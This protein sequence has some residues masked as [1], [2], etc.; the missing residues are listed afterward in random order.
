M[1]K[2]SIDAGANEDFMRKQVRPCPVQS[3]QLKELELQVIKKKGEDE[4]SFSAK[5]IKEKSEKADDE[6]EK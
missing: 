4:V 5:I 1:K 2:I 6:S 3:Q